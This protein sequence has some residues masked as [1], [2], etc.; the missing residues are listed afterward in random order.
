[1]A[2]DQAAVA[3]ATSDARTS[4]RGNRGALLG[5]KSQPLIK[6]LWASRESISTRLVFYFIVAVL[7]TLTASAVAV[8][9]FAFLDTRLKQVNE[10]NVPQMISA[11]EVAQ[12][13]AALAASLPRLSTAAQADFGAIVQSVYETQDAFEIYIGTILETETGSTRAAQ[14]LEAGQAMRTNIEESIEV[15]NRRF[16]LIEASAQ[17]MDEVGIVQDQARSQLQQMLDDQLFYAMTG[18]RN[19][20]DPPVSQ[21]GVDSEEFDTYR[22]LGEIESAVESAAEL[23]AAAFNET[24]ADQLVPLLER[25]EAT[26]ATVD[27]YAKLLPDDMDVAQVLYRLQR[28]F[29]IGLGEESGFALRQEILRLKALE[30]QYII[31]NRAIVENLYAS[32]EALV[33]AASTDTN[34]VTGQ[35]ENATTIAVYLLLALNIAS[36]AGVA[37]I[38]RR[39]VLREIVQ[40]VDRLAERMHTMADGDLEID[41][42]I[43]GNDEITTM[44]EALEVFRQKS[45]EALRL[46]EVERLN[47]ELA[48]S[49]DRLESM[50][51]ELKAAQQQ[52]V[53]REKL[54]A[55]GELTAGVA[56]EIKN[57]LNFMM[58][59]AEVSKELIEELF[60]E[61][62]VDANERDEGIIEEIRGDLSSNLQRIHEHGDRANSIVRDMLAMGRESTDW[63][64][65]D[66]NRILSEHA[67]LAFHSTR[68]ADSEFQLDIKEELDENLPEIE[69]IPA[70]IGRVFLNMFMNGCY[71]TNK[72]RVER[73]E[74]DAYSPTITIRTKLDQD[75]VEVQIEDNG[76]GIAERRNREDLPAVLYNKTNR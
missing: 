35:A 70:D 62:E 7:I 36:I 25:F 38:V 39:F 5:D 33:S 60:E 47:A 34:A 28:L 46:N 53:M 21:A 16:E 49:N 19:L 4:N 43:D 52:I 3:P 9:F 29:A 66:L 10:E 54:A 41:I 74:G 31:T 44:A 61:L 48:E 63:A 67:R 2:E 32:G 64:P 57:P 71:A 15:V 55:M 51:E 1:M 73:G 56:H 76:V 75:N 26:Q 14:L 18:Y 65:T 12:E 27:R 20:N 17:I 22:H 58:N 8:V 45:R 37:I 23:I 30:E 24:D 11:F 72:R 6:R 40:R 50:N 69:A 68:A 59:F 13:S 42:P